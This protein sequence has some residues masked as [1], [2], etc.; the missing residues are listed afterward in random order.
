[1]LC[2]TFQDLLFTETNQEEA[3][4]ILKLILNI[5]ETYFL[6]ESEDNVNHFLNQLLFFE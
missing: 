3:D 5:L 2:N 1:M 6:N 4:V